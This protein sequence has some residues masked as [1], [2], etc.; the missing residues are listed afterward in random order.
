MPTAKPTLRGTN[1]GS[2]KLTS[3][4]L[5]TNVRQ[6]GLWTQE[7]LAGT[8]D[9]RI[10]NAA[11]GINAPR[12]NLLTNGGLEIWQR[13]NG[14][15]TNAF[16][17]DRWGTS[18][19]GAVTFSVSRD[20]V[21]SVTGGVNGAACA[22]CAYTHASGGSGGLQQ[23]L[24]DLALVLRGLTVTVAAMVKSNTPVDLGLSDSGGATF[25]ANHTGDNTY[26]RLVVTMTLGAGITSLDT[27]ITARAASGTFYVDEVMLVV[28]DRPAAWRPLHPADEMARCQRYYEVI[29]GALLRGYNVAGASITSRFSFA[30]RK[31]SSPTMTKVGTFAVTNCGQ[32]SIVQASP[33]GF[34]LETFVTATGDAFTFMDSA[35]DRIVAE[36]NP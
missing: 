14:P 13:G 3:A 25:S 19:A 22:A 9:D 28:G 23:V 29:T 6:Q 27:Q 4:D 20:T 2:E 30:T 33:D 16:A 34:N 36:W 10:P 35:D 15:F 31:G 26:Q 17:A 5:N 24:H 18:T 7:V 32:P 8:S 12:L 1:W 11:L 21:N